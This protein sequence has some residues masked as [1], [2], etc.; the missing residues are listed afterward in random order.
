MRQRTGAGGF[1]FMPRASEKYYR[2]GTGP[3]TVPCCFWNFASH[4]TLFLQSYIYS[5]RKC[6]C[7][8]SSTDALSKHNA[9]LCTW[10]ASS[11]ATCNG[12]AKQDRVYRVLPKFARCKPF[13]FV[14]RNLYQKVGDG[15][16]PEQYKEVGFW[17]IRSTNTHCAN[18]L[19]SLVTSLRL[20]CHGKKHFDLWKRSTLCLEVLQLH[21]QL[22]YDAS[23]VCGLYSDSGPI[24]IHGCRS[25]LKSSICSLGLSR[26]E[27]WNF[28]FWRETEE[29]I[30]FCRLRSWAFLSTK[31]TRWTQYFHPFIFP[32]Y[33]TFQGL[34][35][36]SSIY[37]A[38]QSK[39]P[40]AVQISNLYM[41]LVHM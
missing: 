33:R 34:T 5:Q 31:M 21:F 37:M 4:I 28:N 24:W 35:S 38:L 36:L 10:Q 29:Y 13:K 16:T 8:D 1:S 6:F 20:M 19:K 17:V 2:Y 27:T 25:S 12:K 30:V 14:C 32:P 26:K 9:Y 40:F 11:P 3:L 18:H 7:F 15:L 39:D 22:L 41:D 23:L